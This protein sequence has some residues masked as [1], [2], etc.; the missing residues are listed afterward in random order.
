MGQLAWVVP[1]SIVGGILLGIIPL[2]IVAMCILMTI[3]SPSNSACVF[4][5]V[6]VCACACACV[7]VC[8]SAVFL[9]S[10]LSSELLTWTCW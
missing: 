7:C 6:C 10:H 9:S 5:C 8:L 2:S 1:V 3:V 4:L